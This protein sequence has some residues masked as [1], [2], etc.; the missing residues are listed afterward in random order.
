M[1]PVTPSLTFLIKA[2]EQKWAEDLSY[3]VRDL[4]HHALAT[5]GHADP[6]GWTKADN[7][8]W[9]HRSK[10]SHWQTYARFT[11]VRFD[12][13]LTK[14]IYGTLSETADVEQEKKGRADLIDLTNFP[15]DLTHQIAKTFALTRKVVHTFNES[16]EFDFSSTTKGTVGGP[17]EGSSFEETINV[18]FGTKISD[19]TTRDQTKSASETINDQVICPHDRKT[20]ITYHE[21]TQHTSQPYDLHG[22]PDWA[23]DIKMPDHINQFTSAHSHFLTS[24]HNNWD[25][26]NDTL[27]F[28]GI[29]EFLEFCNGLDPDFPGM[30]DWLEQTYSVQRGAY[31]RLADPSRRLITLSGVKERTYGNSVSFKVTDVTDQDEAAL[32]AIHGEFQVLRQAA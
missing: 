11:D 27:H 6:D 16:L 3:L 5:A 8:F 17:I 22:V 28:P 4:G 12:P 31:D 24:P 7:Q 23:T 15:N 18:H 13:L 1:K 10:H 19:G 26:R 30:K 20:L 29:H 21:Q 2:R 14:L 25:W 32:R 9:Y